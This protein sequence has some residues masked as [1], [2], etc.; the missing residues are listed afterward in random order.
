MRPAWS[1]VLLT[2]L[3]GAGDVPGFFDACGMYYTRSIGRKA[4]FDSLFTYTQRDSKRDTKFE[5]D[6]KAQIKG[7][8]QSAGLN[9]N[10]EAQVGFAAKGNASAELSAAGQTVVKGAMVMIN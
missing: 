3:L 4:K 2:T 9:V 5:A 1:V 10:C 8:G 7:W 6:L